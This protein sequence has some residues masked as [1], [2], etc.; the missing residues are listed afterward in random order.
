MLVRAAGTVTMGAP[1]SFWSLVPGSSKDWR[2]QKRSATPW[3]S[4]HKSGVLRVIDQQLAVH[5]Q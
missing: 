4:M 1:L 2:I 3:I 5:G